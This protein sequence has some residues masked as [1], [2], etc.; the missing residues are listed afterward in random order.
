[1]K[2]IDWEYKHNEVQGDYSILK[3]QYE[4]LLKLYEE[5]YDIRS[6]DGT[7]LVHPGYHRIPGRW[8]CTSA[9]GEVVWT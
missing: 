1:M 7:F 3:L 5:L 4:A 2:Q 9:S 6:N 8:Y